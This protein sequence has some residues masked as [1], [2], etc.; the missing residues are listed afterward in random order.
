M[1]NHHREHDCE[2]YKDDLNYA[3]FNPREFSH[4]NAP[5]F[6]TKC[7]N[8]DAR[9]IPNIPDYSIKIMKSQAG[10]NADK[11]ICVFFAYSLLHSSSQFQ[12]QSRAN[13]ELDLPTCH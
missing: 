9:N 8:D 7:G 11:F 10:D 6:S 12:P 5:S 3:V 13:A 1:C 2:Y 4:R